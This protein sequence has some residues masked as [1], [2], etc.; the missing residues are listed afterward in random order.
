MLFRRKLLVFTLFTAIV[1]TIG[2]ATCL[3]PRQYESRMKVLV[4]NER[5]D[6]VVSPDARNGA[7]FRGDVSEQQVNSEIE[8]L[9]SN[10]LLASVV[11]ACR[12]DER[13]SGSVHASG[14]PSA[15]A[16]ERAVRKLQR[17]LKVTPVHKANIILIRYTAAS[18]G[19]AASVLR[20]LS[21]GYLD[22]H[23]N[24]HRTAGTQQFF[25][26]QA[27]RY[28][29]ELR[30]AE[31]QLSDFRRHNGLTSIAEQKEL[32]L[33]KSLD[34]EAELRQTDAALAEAATR[35]RE[36]RQQVAAQEGRIVTQKRV[37]PNQYSV[38]RLNTMLAELENR[39]T[40]ALMKFHDGDR[41]VV[42]IEQ[43]I[44]NTRAA[45]ERAVRLSG[46]EESTN[47]NPLRQSLE[48]D[49]AHAEL[50]QASLGARRASV[51]GTVAAYHGRL[52]QLEK[53]TI[54]HDA[55][56]RAVKESEENYLLYTRKR[57]E[58]R[59]ADSL[60]QQKIANVAIAE[61]P[62]EQH[63]P[64]KPNVLLNLSL[65]VLLAGFVSMS[66]AFAAEYRGSYFY[67]PAEL[68]AATGLPVLATVPFE[69]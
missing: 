53:D 58:A 32:V 68:E 31:G 2:L 64:T 1:A 19:Q 22:A 14:E 21:A 38:E 41:V 59:I 51:A 23:L 47:V 7:Q 42:E 65:G 24:I 44:A 15:V 5:A 20:E 33:R 3:M 43:E 25:R 40:Q 10:D 11:R 61:A 45:L 50:Q 57:E 16:V 28:E 8:L 62:I 17:D 34:A 49:L 29:N 26:E 6:L 9:N 69:G 27:E 36:L 37:V 54:E 63:V 12:L 13:T 67:S 56:Q 18:P 46:N 35:V 4:K 66:A 55:L 48:G 30:S 52:A 60:D 39:R